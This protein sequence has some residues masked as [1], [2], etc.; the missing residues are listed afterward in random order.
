MKGKEMYK[1]LTSGEV[2]FSK[3]IPG[4]GRSV[5]MSDASQD[6]LKA[7]YDAGFTDLVAKTTVKDASE[8]E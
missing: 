3:V 5:L 1:P 6:V 7:L 8:S 4:V 2:Y